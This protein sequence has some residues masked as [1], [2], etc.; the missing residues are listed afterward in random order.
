MGCKTYS[1][2]YGE[3]VDFC[4]LYGCSSSHLHGAA[5]GKCVGGLVDGLEWERERR[6]HVTLG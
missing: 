4:G 1:L 5:G 2:F 6:G 3:G